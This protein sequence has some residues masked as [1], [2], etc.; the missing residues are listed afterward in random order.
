VRWVSIATLLWEQRRALMRLALI[1]LLVSG[2]VAFLLP[3]HY[4]SKARIM[5]P[6]QGGAAAMLAAMSGKVV[7]TALSALAGNLMGFRNNGP[8]FVDLLSSG[9]VSSHLIDRFNLQTVYWKRYRQDAAKK[10]ARR[11]EISEDRKSGVITITVTDTDRGR[12]RDM[13][14]AYIN[15]LDQLL[16]QVNTSAAGRERLFI[17]Q[18]LASV[19]RELEVAQSDLSEFSSKTTTLDIKDQTRAMVEAGAKLQAQLIVARS[20]V[21][22][23]S[24]I[25]ADENVRVRAAQ[26]R[27]TELERQ[28]NTLAGSANGEASEAAAGQLYPPLRKL[29]ILAV[30][31]ADLYRK[32]KVQEAVF[33]LLTEQYELARIEE[34]R[35]I[36]SVRVIDAPSWPEKKS[37]PPRLL[38]MVF[39]TILVIFLRCW[40]ILARER[41]RAVSELDSRKALAL[42]VWNSLTVPS[43]LPRFR[44]LD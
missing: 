20:E 35:S 30:T 40:F 23:L 27:A 26:A 43:S 16:A 31:W 10:L 4:E 41:W 28:L 9:T 14:Q 17:E 3:K 6:E 18:R 2:I 37:F 7:P 34:A 32:V 36:P 25:Y 22:S 29:P 42:R 33:E 19:Q 1:T 13:T 5:P 39:S 38:I 11:T 15:E 24:Q 44:R 21:Q 12:A 8:L